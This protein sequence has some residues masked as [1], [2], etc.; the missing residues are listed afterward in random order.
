M[1]LFEQVKPIED[2]K[3][4]QEKSLE[5][6]E[7]KVK[8]SKKRKSKQKQE[9]ILPAQELQTQSFNDLEFVDEIKESKPKKKT[10]KKSKIHKAGEQTQPYEFSSYK[11]NIFS[12]YLNCDKFYSQKPYYQ[13]SQEKT[14]FLSNNDFNDFFEVKEN[15]LILNIDD[16]NVISQIIKMFENDLKEIKYI[17][18]F[19]KNIP[20]EYFLNK[21]FKT[22]ERRCEICPF[23]NLENCTLN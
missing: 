21:N 22:K 2:V 3:K 11:N 4:E 16:F 5:K 15:K 18:V 23:F 9:P 19:E 20:K 13:F 10:R 12:L 7:N 14:L 6:K 8:K 17:K 1:N